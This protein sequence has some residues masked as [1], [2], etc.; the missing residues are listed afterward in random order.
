[1]PQKL[2]DIAEEIRLTFDVCTTERDRAL[3]QARTL[4]RHCA[5]AIRAVHRD[6][7]SLAHQHLQEARQLVQSLQDN[8]E[9][10]PD[11]FYAGYTQ[12]A[13]KEYAEAALVYAL[14]NNNDFPDPKD[15]LLE[16]S[17][18]LQGLAEAVGELRRRI[19]DMLLKD[20]P[21]EAE[22]LLGE[23]DD[24]YAILVTM[25][26]PD[27][28]TGGL[29]RLTDVARAIIERTRGDLTL[30]LRQERLENSLRE[31]ESRLDG[32]NQSE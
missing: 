16:P 32:Y 30:S 31:L 21:S 24:I 29:R 28:I 26:Y 8:L 27:A 20:N 22:R 10:Y 14:I 7:N 9:N 1:M 5:N 18:Y 2:E 15:L 23:M 12:D 25:D 13:L 19:L 17:T 4:T 11:L 3:A 6:E